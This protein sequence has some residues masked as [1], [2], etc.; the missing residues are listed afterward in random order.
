MVKTS[1]F[2]LYVCNFHPLE[3]VDCGSETQLQMG[4]NFNYIT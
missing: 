4:G 3:V 2:D 1:I